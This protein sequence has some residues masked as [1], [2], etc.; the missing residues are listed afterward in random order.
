MIKTNYLSCGLKMACAL[1]IAGSAIGGTTWAQEQAPK[2]ETAISAYT[3]VVDEKGNEV[4]E[5]ASTVSPGGIIEY[6]LSYRN[7]SDDALSNFIILGDVP[8]AT[9]YLSA[10]PLGETLAVFEVSVEDI[11]W[12]TPPVIRY[13]DDGDGVLRPVN[14]PEEEFEALRWRLAEP[15]TPGEEVSATYRIKVAQ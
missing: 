3:I 15:I 6:Q 12:A 4:R 8:E 9:E 14:V 2:V 13:I 1:A 5:T 11:G 7:V 10:Q